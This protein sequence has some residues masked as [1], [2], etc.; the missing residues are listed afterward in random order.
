MKKTPMMPLRSLSSA[1]LEMVMMAA[2]AAAVT[3]R[4][5]DERKAA[6]LNAMEF[7]LML[8]LTAAEQ[9]LLNRLLKLFEPTSCTVHCVAWC[10]I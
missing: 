5:D 3:A 7:K 9:L 8:L 10:N 2:A 6:S 4:H 1:Q